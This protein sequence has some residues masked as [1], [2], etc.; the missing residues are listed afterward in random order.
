MSALWKKMNFSFVHH[1]PG[2]R[3]G[4]ITKSLKKKNPNT[5]RTYLFDYTPKLAIQSV[6]IKT[7]ASPHSIVSVRMFVFDYI[8]TTAQENVYLP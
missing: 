2:Y 7:I 1:V 6:F 3:R 8:G 4:S 5:D